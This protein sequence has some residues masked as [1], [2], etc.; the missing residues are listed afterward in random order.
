MVR[1][2]A[3]QLANYYE[4]ETSYKLKSVVDFMQL[5]VA[6]IIMIVMTAITIVSS[7][8]SIIKPKSAP[9]MKET[10]A[11]AFNY[12]YLLAMPFTDYMKQK[13]NGIRNTITRT[14]NR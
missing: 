14:K 13:I 2:T 4:R 7:E 3:L 9:G 6:L 5:W 1:E 11:A 12:L 10:G 8:V